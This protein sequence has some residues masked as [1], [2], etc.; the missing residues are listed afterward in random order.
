[1][2]CEAGDAVVNYEIVFS[3]ANVPPGRRNDVGF[4]TTL[5]QGEEPYE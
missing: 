4:D 2:R 1:M 5:S 3:N